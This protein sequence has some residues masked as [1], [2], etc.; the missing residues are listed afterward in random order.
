ML[1]I[2]TR[3][4]NRYPPV[5][6]QQNLR[7]TVLEGAAGLG[8]IMTLSVTDGDTMA[9]N[10]ASSFSFADG[11]NQSVFQ[12]VPADN[13]VTLRL[14]SPLNFEDQC[15][16]V[17]EIIAI[18]GLGATSGCFFGG[19]MSATATVSVVVSNT[20]EFPP[21]FSPPGPYQ[22]NVVEETFGQIFDANAT[23]TDQTCPT[24]MSGSLVY[25]LVTNPDGIFT[26]NPTSGVISNTGRT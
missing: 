14:N 8:D 10:N 1:H 2:E 19:A 12:L 9:P 4:I 7:E 15:M 17:L 20:N 24:D 6:V 26:I 22:V 21:M 16:Y 11:V 5:Y 25:S 3:Q 23:D 13:S 18:D